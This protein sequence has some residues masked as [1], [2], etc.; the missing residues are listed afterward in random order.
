M[1]NILLILIC[2]PSIGFGQ[3]LLIEEEEQTIGDVFYVVE[4]MPRFRGCTDKK[5]TAEEIFKHIA[6]N[7]TYPPKAKNYGI[8]G[9]V[10]VSFIV[11]KSGKIINVKV[12][13]GVDKYLDAEALRVVKL[14]PNFIPGKQRGKAVNVQYTIPISFQL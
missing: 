9:K 10:F 2:L 7:I 5:C 4:D 1:K 8:Y 13:R 12:S 11:G 3:D 14:L 6:E